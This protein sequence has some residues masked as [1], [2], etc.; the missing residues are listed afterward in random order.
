MVFKLDE[1]AVSLPLLSKL[2]SYTKLRNQTL[3]CGEGDTSG[4]TK[5]YLYLLN[6]KGQPL[7]QDTIAGA[8]G[9]DQGY[10]DHD[11]CKSV[12]YNNDTESVF[13]MLQ[14]KNKETRAY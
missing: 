3:I 6:E 13:V 7:W 2:N 11:K 1:Y 5:G 12:W 8:G 14:S 10:K 4:R 9:R